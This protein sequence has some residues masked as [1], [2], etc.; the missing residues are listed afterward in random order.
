MVGGCKQF[1]STKTLP[2]WPRR[3]TSLIERYSTTV[4]VDMC[5]RIV[6]LP[7]ICTFFILFSYPYFIFK[8]HI[9]MLVV[10]IGQRSSG[11]ESP[12]REEDGTEREGKEGGETEGT[13][14]NGS[15]PQ[16]RDQ[17]PRGQRW[18]LKISYFVGFFNFLR[19]FW[20]RVCILCS[21]SVLLPVPNME[22]E[23]HKWFTLPVLTG[24]VSCEMMFSAS[25]LIIH[26][27]F[28][29]KN[30]CCM[31]CFC[32][33][34]LNEHL[35]TSH[36][37]R[38]QNL[39]LRFGYKICQLCFVSR[40]FIDHWQFLFTYPCPAVYQSPALHFFPFLYHQFHYP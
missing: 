10:S 1:T 27:D 18:V 28:E 9:E 21:L 24:P 13:C 22:H 25:L 6:A 30:Q 26:M 29:K 23:R 19:H 7:E 16:S 11:D 36:Q 15:W 5:F 2:S 38:M 37:I 34:F 4:L 8:L 33:Y 20:V 39:N 12:G 3:S 35:D 32:T 17:K 31:S 14:P 40:K